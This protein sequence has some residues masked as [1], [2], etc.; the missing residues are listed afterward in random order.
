M[1]DAAPEAGVLAGTL[2][3]PFPA[4]M[5]SKSLSDGAEEPCIV[6]STVSP[7]L[8]ALLLKDTA[9]SKMAPP[10]VAAAVRD[11]AFSMHF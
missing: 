6:R 3:A 11:P 4:A 10:K 2:S 1:G 5:P 9:A 7:L 8:A